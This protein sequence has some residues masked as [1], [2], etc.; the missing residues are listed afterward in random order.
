M[1]I[2][3]PRNFIWQWRTRHDP[4]C[5]RALMSRYWRSLLMISA[6]VGVL[7]ASVA[8]WM[9]FTPLR[10]PAPSAS[11]G[12]DATEALSREQLRGTLDL[13]DQKK[14]QH[15]KAKTTPPSISDPAN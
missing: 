1:R 4:D 5:L 2:P 12:Q 3:Y 8:V 13:F 11:L 9:V 6:I 14:L 7:S 15:E 10:L